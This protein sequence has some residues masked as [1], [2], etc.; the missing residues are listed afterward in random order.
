MSV[1][2]IA[3]LDKAGSECSSYFHYTI[4]KPGDSISGGLYIDKNI[5]FPDEIIIRF[6]KGD[7]KHE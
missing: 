7:D 1:T 4:R 6:V 2:I 3:K 5:P